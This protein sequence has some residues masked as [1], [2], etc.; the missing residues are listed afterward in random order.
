MN[1]LPRRAFL[2]HLANSS[3]LGA[4]APALLRAADSA[5]DEKLPPVRAL[6]RGPKFHWFGYYDKDQFSADGRFVLGNQ[7]EFEGRSPRA[8]DVIRV[9]LVD[10]HDGDKWIELGETRAWNWQQGCML[11]WIPGRGHEVIWNDREGD[12]F[13]ARICDVRTRTI[14]TLPHPIYN[15]SPDGRTAIAPDFRRLN[16]T[17][18]GYGYAGVADPRRDELAPADTGLWRTDLATGEQKLLLSFADLATVPFT[19]RADLAFTPQAK[20]WFNHLLFNTDGTR[21]FFL[22]RWR[23]PGGAPNA[24]RTRAFTCDRDGQN[25]YC[26]D[27]HGQTSHFIWRDPQHIMAY[28]WHP[29][30]K[31]RFY[32]YE[33]GTANVA[34]VGPDDMIVNGH[35]TYLPGTDNAWVLNDTY[36]DAQRYQHPY[37]YHPASRRKIALGKF[38]SPPAY[39][40]EWRCDLHPRAS[41][42]GKFVCIDSPHAGGRQLYLIDLRGLDLRA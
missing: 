23:E 20:H 1:P 38:F 8:D 10:L 42:D 19:G 28:A 39:A 41:R 37:L 35:N 17:R 13:V 5:S 6:T 29:T 22:H 34:A 31:Q 27:P 33:D 36:P 30:F 21:F 15:L 4:L 40:G 11:Q 14:R 26:L 24:F 3:A 12:R 32:L 9:G 25:L 2:R 16:D 18:P 7:V